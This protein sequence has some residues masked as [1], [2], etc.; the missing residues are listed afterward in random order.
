MA[1]GALTVA[2]AVYWYRTEIARALA[3][4]RPRLVD[5]ED[6]AVDSWPGRCRRALSPLR[7]AAAAAASALHLAALVI[8]LERCSSAAVA[9][10]IAARAAAVQ[11]AREVIAYVAVVKTALA[12]AAVTVGTAAAAVV[13]AA[14][15]QSEAG[16]HPWRR[17]HRR[18]TRTRCVQTEEELI[19]EYWE[20]PPL[21]HVQV[22]TRDVVTSRALRSTF[23]AIRERDLLRGPNISAFSERPSV[24][25]VLPSAL[26][27]THRD[28]SNIL[29]RCSIFS[30]S[31]SCSLARSVI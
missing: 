4:Y 25:S 12:T 13:T 3:R 1:A 17:A 31:H 30:I 15:E 20:G 18:R 11:R 8:V 6:M 2:S 14:L 22:G 29:L 27:D 10:V 28:L 19:Y 16:G 21:V 26:D 24:L 23:A 7:R 5:V 9:L